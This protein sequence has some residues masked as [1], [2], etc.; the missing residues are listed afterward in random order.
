M[1]AGTSSNDIGRTSAIL[2]LS[3]S[4]D[5]KKEEAITESVCIGN[6]LMNTHGSIHDAW[7]SANSR[8][9]AC[10]KLADVRPLSK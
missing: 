10:T 7:L 4:S 5:V 8:D 6:K 3:S 9:S 2:H 1:A